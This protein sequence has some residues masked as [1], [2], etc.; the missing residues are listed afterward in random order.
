MLC[1]VQDGSV[2]MSGYK[3]LSRKPINANVISFGQAR[4]QTQT[5]SSSCSITA[6]ETEV[7]SSIPASTVDNLDRYSIQIFTIFK[8]PAEPAAYRFPPKLSQ[9]NAHCAFSEWTVFRSQNAPE[10]CSRDGFILS[11]KKL[12]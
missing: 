9:K 8:P 5:D 6:K 4:A 12:K 7:K 2:N 1:I 10:V 11:K 3:G